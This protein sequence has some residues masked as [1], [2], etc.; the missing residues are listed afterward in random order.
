MGE[1]VCLGSSQATKIES[2]VKNRM[3]ADV[4]RAGTGIDPVWRG[5]VVLQSWERLCFS[6]SNPSETEIV[7]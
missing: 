1:R 6:N 4:K 3:A 7:T 5:T 2:A